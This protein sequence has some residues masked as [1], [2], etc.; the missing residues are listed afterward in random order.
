M[1]DILGIVFSKIF[2]KF[3]FIAHALGNKCTTKMSGFYNHEEK[4][5]LNQLLVEIDGMG[6]TI[7]SYTSRADIL[8]SRP[9]EA[10]LSPLSP[11]TSPHCG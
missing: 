3:Y 11:S 6:T 8:D 1:H 4:R 5:T 10:T 9:V 2:I 7:L